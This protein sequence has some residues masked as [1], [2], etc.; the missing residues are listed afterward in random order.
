MMISPV[1]AMLISSCLGQ[2]GPLKFKSPFQVQQCDTI[3]LETNSYVPDSSI[4]SFSIL[5]FKLSSVANRSDIFIAISNS[6]S[7]L[8]F[9]DSSLHTPELLEKRSSFPFTRIKSGEQFKFIF[10]ETPGPGD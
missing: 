2:T 9:R 3:K 4:V 7:I 10:T 5:H 6:G 8:A 1:L